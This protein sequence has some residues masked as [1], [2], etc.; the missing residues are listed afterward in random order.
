MRIIFDEPRCRPTLFISNFI[1]AK[2]KREITN[3]GNP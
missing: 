2:I 1:C 3:G